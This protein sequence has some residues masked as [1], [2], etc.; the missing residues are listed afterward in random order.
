MDDRAAVDLHHFLKRRR[1]QRDQRRHDF[2]EAGWGKPAGR[3][4]FQQDAPG[5]EFDQVQGGGLDDRSVRGMSIAW[6]S[7]KRQ[8]DRR[9]AI[10]ASDQPRALQSRRQSCSSAYWPNRPFMK[11]VALSM[12]DS[13]AV[14]APKP[15]ALAVSRLLVSCRASRVFGGGVPLMSGRPIG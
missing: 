1:F 6:R 5:L 11:L 13:A 14:P 15:E 7:G 9:C 4:F 12:S 8:S 10:M 3:V 2:R